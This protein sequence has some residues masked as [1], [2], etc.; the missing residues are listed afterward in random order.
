MGEGDTTQDTPTNG[1]QGV[2]AQQGPAPPGVTPGRGPPLTPGSCSEGRG[3]VEQP[4][5]PQGGGQ[6]VSPQP[7]LEEGWGLHPREVMREPT[8]PPP[9]WGK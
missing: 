5:V 1:G 6:G 9:P 3:A 7:H 8:S 2:S 4:Q